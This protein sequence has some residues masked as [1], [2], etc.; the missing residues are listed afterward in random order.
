MHISKQTAATVF[1]LAA[2]TAAAA[3]PD[4]GQFQTPAAGTAFAPAVLTGAQEYRITSR[5]TGKTY[6][7]QVAALGDV[8][9]GG[10]PVLYLLDGDI[11]FPAALASAQNMTM[12]LE[13]N[14]AV[15]MLLVG[16]G[17]PGGQLLDI[18]SRSDDY[19]PPSDS[20]AQTGDKISKKF[21]GADA[22]RRF[23]TEELRSDL[24]ARFPVNRKQQ[25][26]FGHSYGGL[27]G[28]Y[29]LLTRPESF[30]N[31]LIASPS[32]WWNKQ[33]VGDFLPA[34]EKRMRQGG[35]LPGVRLSVGAFEQAAVPY[36]KDS[37]KRNELLE[38]RGMVRNTEAVGRTLAALPGGKESV[39]TQV[40]PNDTHA[41]VV[42]PAINDGIRWLYA[43]CK[44][45][46]DCHRAK[47]AE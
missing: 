38:K 39:Q 44:A 9:P 22:F 41:S 36:M 2:C 29:T 12:R 14:N 23:L 13:E 24:A 15:P 11:M 40:Y 46:E 43:R 8:P 34:F 18:P 45:D 35:V 1:A 3:A 20:Y 47:S 10:Y 37:A 25:N 5:H 21:G 16:V 7:I 27:F 19:T 30:R 32:V 6:R 28:L 17:Y 4:A 26:L 33:R 31:Y 42:L